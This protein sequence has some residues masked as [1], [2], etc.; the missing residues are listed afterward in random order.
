M[1]IEYGK[2]ESQKKKNIISTVINDNNKPVVIFDNKTNNKII[3][4]ILLKYFFLQKTHDT[5]NLLQSIKISKKT[6]IIGDK[7]FIINPSKIT[8][9][10]NT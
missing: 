7:G 5:N 3:N 10:N 6:N 8:D 2:D 9:I 1:D 4:K